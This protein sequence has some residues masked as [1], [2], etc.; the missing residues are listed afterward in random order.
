MGVAAKIVVVTPVKNEAWC[1][2]GFLD[3]TSLWADHILIRDQGSSDGSRE[4]ALL[5]DKVSLIDNPSK[6][7]NEA[8]N[9]EALLREARSRFG[10]GNVIISLDADER[11]SSEILDNGL[12]EEIRQLPPGT[13]IRIPFA[14]VH[15][16][17]NRYWRVNIDPIGW[18][19]DARAPE[20]QSPVHFPRTTMTS[21]GKIWSHPSLS[22]IHLQYV[23]AEL[24]ALKQQWYLM[25]ELHDF[26]VRN[27]VFLFRRYMH[28][29]SIEE[30][31]LQ[32]I[33]DNWQQEY[34]GRGVEILQ[35]LEYGESWRSEELLSL[36]ALTSKSDFNKLPRRYFDRDQ[37][38]SA[39]GKLAHGY[40]E[41]TQ[42]IVNNLRFSPQ[43][44]AVRALD[45]GLHLL[46]RL[47]K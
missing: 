27:F 42:G 15:Q 2:D 9:R 45:W 8:E 46:W 16:D 21:L 1:L 14:N 28:T 26:G 47:D 4:S 13:G 35:T 7:Y 22:V 19:D 38:L 23:N 18:V 43:Y 10:P 6:V 17:Q 5:R 39:W 20:N 41:N 44:F 11:L 30:S 29:L 34:R 3:S 31:S 25:K 32:L 36:A 33:P 12:L 37:N 24:F 40:L